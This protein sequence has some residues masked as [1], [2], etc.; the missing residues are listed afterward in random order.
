MWAWTRLGLKCESACMRTQLSQ[1][2][3]ADGFESWSTRNSVSI[4]RHKTGYELRCA[5]S[6]EPKLA[7]VWGEHNKEKSLRMCK[8]D[9]AA[10]K[11]T[12][13]L[14]VLLHRNLNV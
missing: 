13:Y 7:E 12:C 3:C 14:Y 8:M 4:C 11:R 6:R 9:F 1:R 2:F 10:S 5:Y